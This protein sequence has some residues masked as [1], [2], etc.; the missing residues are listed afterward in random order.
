[1]STQLTVFGSMALEALL[2]SP[3]IPV[4]IGWRDD[5]E[6]TVY[7]FQEGKQTLLNTRHDLRNH[8]PTGP[9]WGYNGSG[10]AQ[11]ALG[12]ACLVLPDK[13]ALAVYQHLKRKLVSQIKDNG[14]RI[15]IDAIREA[16]LEIMKT[17]KL[18]PLCEC[19]GKDWCD[20]CCAGSES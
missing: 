4:V 19:N 1:M 8:S 13:Q 9:N 18:P 12:L 5:G 3:D 16:V 15:P 14:W 10:P 2:V 6:A 11:L 7:V 20:I 17:V